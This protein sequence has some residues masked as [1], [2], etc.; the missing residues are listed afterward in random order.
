[1]ALIGNVFPKLRILKN[2]VRS[3]FKKSRFR[4]PFKKQHS[5]RVQTLFKSE[6]DFLGLFIDHCGG[7]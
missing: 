6:R 7:Y 1:M 5:K 2:V 4:G 3:I